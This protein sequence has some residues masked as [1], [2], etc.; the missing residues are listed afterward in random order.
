MTPH[1]SHRR[2]WGFSLP[3]PQEIRKLKRRYLIAMAR[4][5]R[6]IV[7]TQKTYKNYKGA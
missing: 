2:W 1:F 4:R 5:H 7:A 6:L 3:P